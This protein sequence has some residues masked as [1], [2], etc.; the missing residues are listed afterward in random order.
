MFEHDNTSSFFAKSD[1]SSSNTPSCVKDSVRSLVSQYLQ[2]TDNAKLDNIYDWVLTEVEAP[3]LDEVM[4]H[5]RGNQTQ[6]AIMLGLNRG[7]LRK[8]LKRYGMI[9]D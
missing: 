8:K 5:A 2:G 7:T 9:K 3:L 4:K 1:I 6:A